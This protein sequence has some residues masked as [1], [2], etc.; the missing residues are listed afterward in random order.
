MTSKI[1]DGIFKKKISSSSELLSNYSL[2][3]SLLLRRSN[4]EHEATDR[5]TVNYYSTIHALELIYFDSNT[6]ETMK[7][8]LYL[9]VSSNLPP[10]HW[11]NPAKGLTVTQVFTCISYVSNVQITTSRRH[12]PWEGWCNKTAPKSVTHFCPVNCCRIEH[13]FYHWLYRRGVLESAVHCRKP[14]F[15]T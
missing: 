4:H 11:R 15:I 1:C 14:D 12:G 7:K 6:Q 13:D 3:G 8:H 2:F 5:Q 9:L 10:L